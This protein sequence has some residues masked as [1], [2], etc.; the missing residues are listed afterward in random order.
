MKREPVAGIPGIF[1]QR[2]A[3]VVAVLLAVCSVYATPAFVAGKSYRIVCPGYGS[4]SLLTGSAHSLATP[5]FYAVGDE[6]SDD[7]WWTFSMAG[8][9]VYTIRN[10]ATGQYLTYDGERTDT[11]RYVA[12]TES[13]DS[14][15]SL[16]RISSSGEGFQIS[17]AQNDN[18]RLNVRSGDNHMTGT[19]ESSGTAAVNEVFCF[20]DSNGGQVADYNENLKFALC[21]DS[22]LI[23]GKAPVPDS[24]TGE[25]LY[26]VKNRYLSELFITIVKVSLNDA[27]LSL[28]IDGKT[29]TSGRAFSF[30]NVAGG[31]SVT[32]AVVSD[33]GTVATT[34]L[35]FTFMP[36]VEITGSGF[37]TETYAGGTLR[38]VNAEESGNDTVIKAGLRY[39]GATAAGK[40]K[41]SYAIKL[42]DAAGESL[43]CQFFGLRSD[44]NWILDAMAIDNARMR[45][46]VS[47]D[48][49]L[50]FSAKPYQTQ[51]K[52]KAVNG[53]RGRFV[54]V[55]LN[56]R[57][58]GIYCMTEKVD[59]KQLQLRK[60]I[61][62]EN[63]SEADT[64]RGVLY[65]SVNWSYSVLMGH[66]PDVKSYPKT[67]VSSASTLSESWDNWEAK[68]PDLSD[69]QSIDWEPL[70]KLVNLVA[71]SNRAD[72]FKYLEDYFDLPVW[73][74]YYLFVELLLATDNHGK[75][76]YLYNYDITKYNKFSVCPW[77][78]DGTW[79]MRWD[80]SETLTADATQNYITFL[81]NYEHGENNFYRLLSLYDYNDWNDSLASRYAQ[82]RPNWFHPDS[83]Y[84]RFASYRQLFKQ[85]GADVREVSAWNNA[86]GISL[87][88]DTELNYL[89]NWIHQRVA[90]LDKQYGFDAS[91]LGVQS[92][93]RRN[94][95]VSGGHGC[96]TV[97]SEGGI[98][99]HIRNTEGVLLR[100]VDAPS[101]VSEVT[102][103]PP[104][105]YIAGNRKVLV[106]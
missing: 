22:L 60:L 13:P 48:L 98:R 61:E 59:R 49:W 80:G 12:L 97:V 42:Y 62:S 21:V 106:K 28:Q 82:L 46:R 11:K 25:Y 17:L 14:A 51:Y 101:G 93:V 105:I 89:N 71:A 94:F 26:T 96:I 36:I 34:K 91:T 29:V 64:V 41:K 39:R 53:T 10:A 50:D 70:R 76:E 73:R 88:F 43:D 78:L 72:F 47:T 75:N 27:A 40:Q 57:Y 90:T 86:D 85:S 58:A 8:S 23:G 3:V 66:E 100:T 74:D 83:L 67:E 102:G 19:Y 7:A 68:Y 52:P 6:S 65:K 79:G 33:T 54:E 99:L 95:S 45:N 5:I 1:L 44:N 2:A 77:D 56:G 24:K 104:G 84:Q 63:S 9:G 20:Y 87:K 69:A 35:N 15:N 4:G 37:N 30:G 55:F 31:K 38:V 18:N 16:W 103:L 92:A 32:L 81:W